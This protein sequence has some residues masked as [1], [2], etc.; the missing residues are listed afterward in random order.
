VW[1][2]NLVFIAL[3]VAGLSMLGASLAPI[4]KPP[5]DRRLREG[6]AEAVAGQPDAEIEKLVAQI[7]AAFE[8]DWHRLGLVPAV[9]ADDLS[10]ARRLSLAL[11]GMVPSLEELRRF[12]AETPKTRL[13][14]WREEL[15]VDRRTHDYLAERFARA[16]VGVQ[17]GPFI[18]YRRRRFVA[19]LADQ[20]AANRPYNQIV[21]DLVADTGLWTDHP[22][23]NF[24]SVTVRPDEEKGPDAGALA[25]RTAR[26]FLGVRLDCAECHDHPFEP[27]KQADFQSLA[28]F[29]SQARKGFTGIH[30]DGEAGF[31]IENRLTGQPETIAPR[32]PFQ[33]ELLPAE[34]TARQRL[35]TWITHAKNRSFGRE[36]VNRVWAQLLGKPLV[37]PIDDLGA[38]DLEGDHDLTGSREV[39]AALG[40][41]ADD[42]TRH[43]YDLRRLVRIITETRVF[44][45]DSRAGGDSAGVEATAEQE[46]AWA[47]FPISRLRPEQVIGGVMQACRLRTIDYESNLLTRIIRV[48]GQ[49]DFIKR[50]GDAGEDEFAPEGGTIPQR[51]LMM[52]GDEVESRVKESIVS[53]AA[54]QIAALAASDE[55]A[56]E[57][58]YL[59][60]L[61]RRPSDIETRHFVAQLAAAANQA[62][63]R[64]RLEDLYWCLLNSTEFSWNH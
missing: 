8:R 24:I 14:V 27:W 16:Y 39:P 41:L 19:W 18:F 51:L 13:T 26:A 40:L 62:E 21:T 61:T 34:G 35:A 30:D 31:E 7:D 12:E 42:F 53:N 15:L 37:E 54:S 17:D 3:C 58:S 36:I 25:A 47:V 29:F 52:N 23:T 6:Q 56:V 1:L 38:D 45:L 49:N 50:Y 44:R 55:K 4:H 22:A 28:A 63:R 48:T 11:V 64:Q 59:T 5:R 43:G 2:R 60:T 9:R 57:V 20:L 32:V 33:P 10:V 46:A